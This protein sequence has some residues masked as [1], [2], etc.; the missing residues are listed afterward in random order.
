MK[1]GEAMIHYERGD[2]RIKRKVIK[3]Q[4]KLKGKEKEKLKWVPLSS[5]IIRE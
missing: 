1:Y 2:E 3:T 4:L 5:P